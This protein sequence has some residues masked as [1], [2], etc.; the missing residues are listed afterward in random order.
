[1]RRLE[2]GDAAAFLVDQDGSVIA[3]DAGPQRFNEVTGLI[4]RPAIAL[5]Q[6]EAERIGIGK[7]AALGIQQL[8]TGAAQDRGA[9]PRV[10]I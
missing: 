6:D 5:E 8:R 4:G 10:R 3:P 7:K 2:A 1:M 9:G